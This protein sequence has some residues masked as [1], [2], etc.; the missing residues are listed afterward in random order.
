[1]IGDSLNKIKERVMRIVFACIVGVIVIS[2][3]SIGSPGGGDYDFDPPVVVRSTPKANALHVKDGKIEIVF[4]ELIQVE[5]PMDKVIVTPPQKAFPVIRA[6][7]NKV[8]VELR[9]SLKANTTY[10]IDFTDA[11]VDNNEKNPLENFALSFSTGDVIDSLA[12]S[13]K[14][15][16][17][18]NLEPVAG[19][20]VG[21]HSDLSDTAFTNLPFLR[22]SRTNE[23]GN[24]SIK[25][26]AP[27][28]YKVYALDDQ[29]RDYKYDS[30]EEAIAFYDSVIVPSFET[31]IRFDS[32][33]NIK[34]FLFDSLKEVSY[35]RFTPDDIVL[36]SFASPFKRQYLQKHERL[37]DDQ[38]SIYFGAPTQMPQVEALGVPVDMSEWSMLERGL[39]NDTLKYWLTKPTMIEMDTITLKVSY[40]VTDTLNQLQPKT[41]T[42]NF[43][44]RLKKREPK[45][46]DN[47]KKK[48]KE[49][50][51]PS[52]P[53]RINLA[54]VFDIYRDINIEFGYP[55]MDFEKEKLRLQHR[56]DSVFKDV[57]F[58]LIT[59]SLNPR[60]Y[61]IKYNWVAEND[62]QLLV[63]SGS[64]H[65]YNGL[66]NEAL[67]SKFKIKGLD[68]YGRLDVYIHNLPPG[69]P[70][71]MELLNK[72]DIPV[73]N[74]KVVDGVAT[75]MY[76]DPDT[77]YARLTIDTN[78]NGKWD[79]G[80]YSE[81]R[82]PELVV[83]Y[84]KTFEI[85]AFWDIEEDWD[86]ESV[87]ASKQKP[88][89]ITK[90][91]PKDTDNRRRELQRQ[92]ARNNRNNRNNSQQNNNRNNSNNLNRNNT[93]SY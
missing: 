14:V 71:F 50:A 70:A 66:T 56:A 29:N 32:V 47:K 15:L 34:T 68:Q 62:Y 90:N 26:I 58:Q 92:E 3:A 40:F 16:A 69:V 10:T 12:I 48:G 35:T 49:E 8:V 17:A 11:I 65:A 79:P 45:K 82:E 81:G 83:Y 72:S 24:F 43:V 23:L 46:E 31:A 61:R 76:L 13:G 85:K 33:F 59:D 37:V 27:G 42:L 91:K 51:T 77:Y 89:E 88:L 75:F 20:Y 54:G 9:D 19:M 44:N 36:R 57:D 80:E 21:I 52:L 74:V 5:K 55:L 53:M 64:F 38:L 86:I 18:D 41:D 30:P 63:D 73:R 60:K 2:C 87:H 25:G 4:D 78:G 22:I 84:S 39:G 6:Q 67:D 28:K 93:T 7:N 1:M